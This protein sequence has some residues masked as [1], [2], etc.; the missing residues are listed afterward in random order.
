MV[1]ILEN[2][3]RIVPINAN[4]EKEKEWKRQE[5]TKLNNQGNQHQAPPSWRTHKGGSYQGGMRH[6]QPANTL[7]WKISTH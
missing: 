4:K 5:E 6:T 3:D 2:F 1:E 7:S